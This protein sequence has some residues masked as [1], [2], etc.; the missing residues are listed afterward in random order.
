MKKKIIILGKFFPPDYG[1]I[2]TITQIIFSKIKTIKQELIC[3]TRKS[4]KNLISN[5][6]K[7]FFFE[8][9]IN[10]LSQPLNF[11]YIIFCFKKNFTK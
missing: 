3:F 2:E 6:N 5:K 11:F 4:R 9:H 7:I 1:G 8:N 10:L